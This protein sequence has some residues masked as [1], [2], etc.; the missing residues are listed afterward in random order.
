MKKN[1]YT[2]NKKSIDNFWNQYNTK[3]DFPKY[4]TQ[5]LNLANKNAQATRPK[6]V[7]QLSE[8]FKDFLLHSEDKTLDGWN[9]WY[10]NKYPDVMPIIKDK[11]TEQIN[12]LKKSINNINDKIIEEWISDLLSIKTYEGLYL[13]K[14]ILY[15]L[16]NWRNE[17]CRLADINEESQGID[18]FIGDKPYSVKPESYENKNLNETINCTIIYYKKNKSNKSI[19]F[20]FYE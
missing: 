1:T 10:K 2:I 8:L 15:Q 16:A 11:I 5:I 19:E 14:L 12:N 6:Y 9:N 18:G 7:G 20:Y 13:Q 4:S 3:F 17:T